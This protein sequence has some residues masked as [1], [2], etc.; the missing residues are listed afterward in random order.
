MHAFD[1]SPQEAEA[2]GP[3][4]VS[5][6]SG[7]HSKSLV[8]GGVGETNVEAET[9]SQTQSP[10][11]VDLWKVKFC[12]SVFSK[13]IFQFTSTPVRTTERHLSR[14]WKNDS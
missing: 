3:L 13:V 9:E 4:C 1:P 7:V 14:T 2:G 8:G 11:A 6:K 5:D 12:V 10:E